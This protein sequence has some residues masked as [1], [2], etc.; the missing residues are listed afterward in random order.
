[1]SWEVVIGIE[2]HVQ[3]KTRNKI[4]Q[5]HPSTINLSQIPQLIMLI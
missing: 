5:G 4:F 3:L 1:M 2:T